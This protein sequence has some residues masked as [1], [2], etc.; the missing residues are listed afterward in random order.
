ML[1]DLKNLG[2]MPPVS[3]NPDP[4]IGKKPDKNQY[5]LNV[6]VK[7]HPGEINIKIVLLYIH[8][9]KTS[10]AKALLKFLFI[11]KKILKGQNLKRGPKFYVTTKNTLAGESLQDCKINIRGPVMK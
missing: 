6:D 5:S 9:S 11:L 1:Q 4:I 2:M 8:I 10:S 7:T 3:F